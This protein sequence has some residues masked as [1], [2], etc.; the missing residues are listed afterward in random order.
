[1]TNGFS[2]SEEKQFNGLGCLAAQF[3]AEFKNGVGNLYIHQP[4]S[5]D[6]GEE[7]VYEV[8]YKYPEGAF[9]KPTEDSLTMSCF[10]VYANTMRF[11]GKPKEF[12]KLVCKFDKKKSAPKCTSIGTPKNFSQSVSPVYG[13]IEYISPCFFVIGLYKIFIIFA[14]LSSIPIVLNLDI[15]A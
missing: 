14:Q 6:C 13:L 3:I 4:D 8:I 11:E 15:S 7:Y 10:D 12:N 9:G 2:S 5:K 1:M